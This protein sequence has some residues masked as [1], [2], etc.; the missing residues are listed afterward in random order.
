[1]KMLG[2]E[3]GKIEREGGISCICQERPSLSREIIIVA[4]QVRFGLY[5]L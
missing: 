2:M 1:M 3:M 5:I 4:I